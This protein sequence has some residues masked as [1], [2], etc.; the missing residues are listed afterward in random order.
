MKL[1]HR[2]LFSMF[3][4]AP[5]FMAQQIA[6]LIAAGLIAAGSSLLQGLFGNQQAAEERKRKMLSEA[7]GMEYQGAVQGAQQIGNSQQH[8]FDSLMQGYKSALIR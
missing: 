1:K 4:M 7:Q 5:I 8:A 3:L 2:L 6:P